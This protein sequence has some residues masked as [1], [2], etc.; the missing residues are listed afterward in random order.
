M[1][2]EKN[3]PKGVILPKYTSDNLPENLSAKAT[4]KLRQILVDYEKA[5]GDDSNDVIETEETLEDFCDEY[6][7][8]FS[9]FVRGIPPM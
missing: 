5:V 3:F 9:D 8:D 2:C 7:L 4:K 1:C 6:D